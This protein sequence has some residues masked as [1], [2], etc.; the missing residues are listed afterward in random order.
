[1]LYA[2][3]SPPIARSILFHGIE[4][5]RTRR[6]QIDSGESASLS[7]AQHSNEFSRPEILDECESLRH[8]LT[9]THEEP[10]RVGEFTEE[11]V[12]GEFPQHS[13]R[14]LAKVL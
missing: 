5:L 2:A 1:M 7:L 3:Q 8:P 11:L 12:C 9:T 6:S 14:V 13:E 10:L 4:E